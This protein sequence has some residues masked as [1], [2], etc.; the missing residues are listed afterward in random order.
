MVRYLSVVWVFL[1]LTGCLVPTDTV[2]N[3]EGDVVDGDGKL[4]GSC[5]YALIEKGDELFSVVSSGKF[6]HSVVL[7]GFNYNK[8]RLVVECDNGSSKKTVRLPKLP[9]SITEY[10]SFG[11]LVIERAK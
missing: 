1:F 3:I 7:G 4:Y 9:Q 2:I 11:T 10:V 5:N 8:A 6:H